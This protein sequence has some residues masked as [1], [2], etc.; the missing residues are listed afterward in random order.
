MLCFSRR[1]RENQ[2]QFTEDT[3]ELKTDDRGN[4]FAHDET[5]KHHR[6]DV[7]YV[8]YEKNLRMYKT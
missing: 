7:L 2:R 1:G 6:G 5:T 4:E 8:N 3:L